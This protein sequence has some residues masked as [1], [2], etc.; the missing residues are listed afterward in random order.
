[1]LS[2]ATPVVRERLFGDGEHPGVIATHVY[3]LGTQWWHPLALLGAFA[4]AVTVVAAA[5]P[6]RR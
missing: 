4:L 3:W 5:N 2:L 1:M 6:R